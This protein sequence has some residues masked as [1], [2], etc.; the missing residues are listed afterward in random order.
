MS[1]PIPNPQEGQTWTLNGKRFKVLFAFR[2]REGFFVGLNSPPSEEVI[3]CRPYE[4]NHAVKSG[5]RPGKVGAVKR[6]TLKAA[7]Q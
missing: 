7:V 3:Y 6:P 5:I 2:G 1:S 4:W